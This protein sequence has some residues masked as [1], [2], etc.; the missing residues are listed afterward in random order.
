MG[1]GVGYC[2]SAISLLLSEKLFFANVANTQGVIYIQWTYLAVTLS[3]VL[4]GLFYYY[5]PLPE[6]TDVE[7]RSRANMLWIDPSLRFFGKL[8]VVVSTLTLGALAEFCSTASLSSIRTFVG[9]LLENVSASTRT[10]PHLTILNFNISLS[11]IYAGSHFIVSFLCLF[12]QPRIILLLLY[13]C[14]IT[15]SALILWLDFSS[16]QT[17]E[18]I[19]LFFAI[20]LGP[21]PSLTYAMALRGMGSW[22]KFGASVLEGCGDLGPTIYPWVMWAL[23]RSHSVQFS[24]CVIFTAFF[25]GTVFP[26]YLVLVRASLPLARYP[27]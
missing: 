23:V 27:V 17:P 19:V 4:L 8:P 13:A 25:I 6:A 18:Y 2:G 12:I 22:T 7:L 5:I 10:S 16:A 1:L 9:T 26:L 15:I 21:I 14:G 20:P 11:A 3:M 24:F